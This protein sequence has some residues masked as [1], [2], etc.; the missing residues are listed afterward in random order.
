MT[1]RELHWASDQR[2]R[3]EWRQTASVIAATFEPHRNHKRRSR[4]YTAD[5]FD[6]YAQTK[7]EPKVRGTIQCLRALLS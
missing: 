3:T 5:D 7:E 4:P 6:P 2:L 1:L